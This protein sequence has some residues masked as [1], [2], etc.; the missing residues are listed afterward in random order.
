MTFVANCSGIGLCNRLLSN[1]D[2]IN[3]DKGHHI[4][5]K[6]PDNNMTQGQIHD[7][8]DL[9]KFGESFIYASIPVRIEPIC[10]QTSELPKF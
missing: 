4:G 10:A 3:G 1:I 5:K 9:H 2:K 8:T 6:F 7:K